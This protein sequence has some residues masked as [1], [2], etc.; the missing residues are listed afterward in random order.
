MKRSR[1]KGTSEKVIKRIR[2]A[3]RGPHSACDKF[4]IVVDGL[5]GEPSMPCRA[6]LDQTTLNVDGKIVNLTPG[7]AATVEIRTGKRKMIEFILSPLIEIR[8]EDRDLRS[9]WHQ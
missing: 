5:R 1:R 9:R 6:A 8:G 4:R 7:M 2:R 3:T